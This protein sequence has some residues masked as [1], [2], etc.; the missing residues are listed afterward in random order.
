MRILFVIAALF[1]L[2]GCETLA[3]DS[4]SVG[5]SSHNYGYNHPSHISYTLGFY[6]GH[7]YNGYA[8]YGDHG[9]RYYYAPRHYTH[10]RHY[11]QPHHY[12]QPRHY[13]QPTHHYVQPQHHTR[14]D[15][16]H[17]EVTPRHTPPRQRQHV[18][19]P[20]PQRQTQNRHVDREER[21]FRADRRRSENRKRK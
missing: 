3:L 17:R 13:V 9:H 5:V 4:V 15:R 14:N 2:S 19:P 8:V 18:A 20:Q 7:H 6:S 21:K 11:T 10:H 1:M 12:V 16:Q